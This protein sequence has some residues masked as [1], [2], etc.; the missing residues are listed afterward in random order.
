M[1]LTVIKKD[2]TIRSREGVTDVCSDPNAGVLE[3]R[4]K[5]HELLF[6]LKDLQTWALTTDMGAKIV[7]IDLR[8]PGTTSVKR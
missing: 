7:E 5:P 2:G 8:D 6:H 1:I 4:S 3:A